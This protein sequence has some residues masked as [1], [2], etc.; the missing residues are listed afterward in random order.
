MS[1]PKRPLV[2]VKA[3][4]VS[5][6]NQE[7]LQRLRSRARDLTFI[8][9]Y[10][11]VRMEIDECIRRGVTP[12]KQLRHRFQLIPTTAPRSGKPDMQ[13]VTEYVA[14]GYQAMPYDAMEGMGYKIPPHAVKTPTGG[15]QIG[16]TQLY[17]CDAVTAE[18]HYADGRQAIEDATTDEATSHT[19][20]SAGQGLEGVSQRANLT[21]SQTEHRLE[22]TKG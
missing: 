9:G 6:V 18:Q 1:S 16:D 20:H 22:V 15:V 13:R 5:G 14:N 17:F 4:E 12:T 19:L 3:Q 2:S 7:G 10:S 8:Q 21:T 11:D